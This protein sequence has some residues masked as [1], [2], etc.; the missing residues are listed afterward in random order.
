[1]YLIYVWLSRWLFST[2]HKSI[3]TLYFIFGAFAGVVGTM[4]NRSCNL[5][6]RLKVSFKKN[7]DMIIQVQNMV[8]MDCMSGNLLSTLQNNSG[9]IISGLIGALGC[10]SFYQK[11]FSSKGK[12]NDNSGESSDTTN[13]I[14][15]PDFSTSLENSNTLNNTEN[16]I[17]EIIEEGF[18]SI[19]SLD[20]LNIFKSLE[21]KLDNYNG[22]GSNEEFFGEEY[23]NL[24][25]DFRK[26]MWSSGTKDISKFLQDFNIGKAVEFFSISPGPYTENVENLINMEGAIEYFSLF[27]LSEFTVEG[28]ETFD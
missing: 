24:I 6:P 17:R 26:E 15:N 25:L 10:F 11:W 3:G 9:L 7:K 19:E 1:M 21:D 22:R 28:I 5:K 14:A 12:D 16:P 23:I 13:N 27:R 8:I 18:N 20:P 4:K 2:N